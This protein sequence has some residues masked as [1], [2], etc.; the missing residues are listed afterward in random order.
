MKPLP[1][2]RTCWWASLAAVILIFG[3]LL[4]DP[5][6]NVVTMLELEFAPTQEAFFAT[7][8]DS[9]YTEAFL[10]KCIYIDYAFIVAFTSLFYFSI[11]IVGAKYNKK[12]SFYHR[13]FVFFPGLLDVFEDTIMLDMVRHGAVSKLIYTLQ[14]IMVYS[15]WLLVIPCSI[16]VVMALYSVA[17]TK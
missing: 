14:M 16:V 11:L 2:L 4:S 12:L 6:Y 8:A 9:G 15:K 7:I 10:E 3:V 17:R 1:N 13:L 5:R